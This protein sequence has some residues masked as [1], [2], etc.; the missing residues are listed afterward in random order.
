MIVNIKQGTKDSKLDFL[1]LV[2]DLEIQGYITY[3]VGCC[4]SSNHLA[5]AVLIK[6]EY[7]N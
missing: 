6:D 5:E 2:E 7:R 3:S 1:S 4:D